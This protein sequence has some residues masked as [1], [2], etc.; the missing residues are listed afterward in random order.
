MTEHGTERIL[1]TDYFCPSNRGDAAI[2][3]GTLHALKACFP[4]ASFVVHTSYPELIPHLHDVE[5]GY[6]LPK[7]LPAR[8]TGIGAR[9]LMMWARARRRGV[10][11]PIPHEG[12]RRTLRDYEEADIVV[13]KGG[14]Y[15][16]DYYGDSR[17][18]LWSYRIA[19]ALGKTVC[20]S[21]QSIGPLEEP[22]IR[23]LAAT[24]FREIDLIVARD[25]ST[26]EVLGGLNLPHT[27]VELRADLAFAMPRGDENHQSMPRWEAPPEAE[28]HGSRRLTLSV[29]DWSQL[30]P[31]EE[32]RYIE[33]FA[34]LAD[35]AAEELGTPCLFL[36]TCTS[37]G[38][39]YNDD[40]LKAARIA[41]RCQSSP[42][43]AAFDYDPYEIVRLM[44]A[45]SWLHVGTR[46]HSNVLALLA[47][48]PIV[49]IA[50]EPKIEG[51]A[52]AFG[53]EDYVLDIKEITAE[54]L[55]DRVRQALDNRQDL[56]DH[57]AETLPDVRESAMDNAR[58][59]R[60]VYERRQGTTP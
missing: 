45:H 59:I 4:N 31:E 15:L 14:G 7:W 29:R 16:H 6:A 38:G 23:K 53:L 27:Q 17:A 1:I 39:Y 56:A 28:Q 3:E 26:A 24:T 58:L 36:S 54:A 47:G 5:A 2:F 55:I 44:T 22:G 32:E 50:Y 42:E 37:L 9:Y 52:E 57:I 20:L 35:W 18:R 10:N 25:T 60:D 21:G 41:E 33:S 11:L 48:V 30:S 49:G 12:L 51:L 34:A 40:R 19:R 8:I 13:A 43:I 46:M